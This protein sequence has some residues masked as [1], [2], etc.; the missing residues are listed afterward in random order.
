MRTIDTELMRQLR[1]SVTVAGP[2][3]PIYSSGPV[4]SSIRRPKEPSAAEQQRAELV[5]DLKAA[6]LDDEGI[7]NMIALI[8][9]MDRPLPL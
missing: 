4:M 2:D 6:G 8:A 7:E 5:S 9:E 1:A 3:D